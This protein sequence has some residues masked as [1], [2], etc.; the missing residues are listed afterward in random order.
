MMYRLC[1]FDPAQHTSEAT[2]DLM[3]SLI[4]IPCWDIRIII[5][6]LALFSRKDN[7]IIEI[8]WKVGNLIIV[9]NLQNDP[10]SINL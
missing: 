4:S 8:I 6:N 5:R 7:K 10:W 2:D 3:D 1:K 9:A